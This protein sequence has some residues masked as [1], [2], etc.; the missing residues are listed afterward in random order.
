MDKLI[1]YIH[2]VKYCSAVKTRI[3]AMIF[4]MDF[5]NNMKKIKL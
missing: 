1:K 3:I 2:T 5:K 4:N